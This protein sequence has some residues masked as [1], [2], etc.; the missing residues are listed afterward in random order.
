[1][2]T[3]LSVISSRRTQTNT[4]QADRAIGKTTPQLNSNSTR[5]TINTNRR[6]S[7]LRTTSR[8]TGCI[9]PKV[10]RLLRFTNQTVITMVTTNRFLTSYAASTQRRRTKP[11]VTDAATTTSTAQRTTPKRTTISCTTSDL[12]T[13]PTTPLATFL[14][15]P[16]HTTPR[17]NPPP[18]SSVQT[19][20]FSTVAISNKC[21]P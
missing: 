15:P 10:P 7:L 18:K 20:N 6:S 16:G 13:P 12:D 4:T 8:T 2:K 5:P 14:R 21:L 19:W 9:T 3:P 11:A 1:M 17:I